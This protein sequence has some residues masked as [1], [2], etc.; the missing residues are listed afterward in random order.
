MAN[1]QGKNTPDYHVYQ[2]TG[3]GD[4]A[5]WNRIGAAWNIKDGAINVQLNSIPLDGKIQLRIP[6]PNDES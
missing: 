4:N 3:E 5:Y 2:I 6:K 1:E